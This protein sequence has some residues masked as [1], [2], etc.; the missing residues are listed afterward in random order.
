MLLKELHQIRRDRRIILSLT[1]PP[2]L[3]LMLFGT[4]MSP[5]VA[6]IRLGIV[7]NSHSP[8]SRALLAALGES[9]SFELVG[10]Y[11]SVER[12]ADD[13]SDGA[14]DAGVVMPAALARDLARGRPVTLQVLL[15]AMNANTAAISQGYLNG[16]LQSYNRT[17]QTDALQTAIRRVTGPPPR[18]G[19]AFLQPTFLF[20]PGLV[21]S[22]FLVTGLLGQL[23]LMNGMITASTT[24]VK[25]REAGTL[26][27]L[28]MTPVRIS[29]I[30]IAKIAPPFVLFAIPATMA[31]LVIRLYFKVPF[32]GSATMLGVASAACLLGGI[33]LGTAVATL[34]K[35]AQQAQLASF[36]IMPPM[37]SLSGAL[38]PAEAM[39]KWLQP[40]T[41]VNPV[42]NFGV[43]SRGTM[44]RG[45]SFME[46]WPN[47]V[48]LSLFAIVLM[49]VSVW[50]FRQQLN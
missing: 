28:L 15:N 11:D 29:E 33:G 46:L 38:T 19:V 21:S 39:P 20:N 40:I 12:L 24:M 35:S 10:G 43:I 8:P 23:L 22:W 2:I 5:D 50:R 18:H 44:I 13:I 42:Y 9:G 47:L 36:F 16:V 45:S 48:A 26:E 1:L 41:V 25:E 6:N 31:L 7:D 27:Q 4:V 17:L 37:M 49:S 14:L 3:Q 32:N 30:I 34:T